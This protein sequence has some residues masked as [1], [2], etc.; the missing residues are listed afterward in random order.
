MDQNETSDTSVHQDLKMFNKSA[1]AAAQRDNGLR[2]TGVKA[3]N[4]KQV[5]VT[6]KKKIFTLR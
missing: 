1:V 2:S 6:A 5:S 3:K 4:L